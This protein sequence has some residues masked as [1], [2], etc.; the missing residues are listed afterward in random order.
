M[1]INREEMKAEAIRRMKKM[2]YFELSIEEFEK[3]DKV[4]VNEPPFGAHYYIDDEADLVAAIK[5][6]EQEN[7][8]LVY[9][10]VRAFL[11]DGTTNFKMDSLLYVE[12]YKEEWGFFDADIEENIVMSYTINWTWQ[13]CSEFGSIRIKRTPAAGILRDVA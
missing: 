11:T 2:G 5:E 4:M 1:S 7:D 6:F 12:A 10:V 3:H 13:D 8:A 9:A